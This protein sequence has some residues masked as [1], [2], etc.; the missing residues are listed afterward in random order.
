MLEHVAQADFDPHGHERAR[1]ILEGTVWRGRALQRSDLLPTAEA[2][3]LRHVA[4]GRAWP[5]NTT[6]QGYLDSL[7]GVILDPSSG[8]L[9]SRSRRR[10]GS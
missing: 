8:V 1:Q 6:L 10:D 7:R 5:P 2:H 9:V 3:Y 4:V